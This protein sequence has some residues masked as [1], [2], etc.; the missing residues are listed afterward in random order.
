MVVVN[1]RHPHHGDHQLV[2]VPVDHFAGLNILDRPGV[3]DVHR[4]HLTGLGVLGRCR[5]QVLDLAGVEERDGVAGVAL[6]HRV[7]NLGE[8]AVGHRR[9]ASG[10]RPLVDPVEG[11]L[12][13]GGELR[14]VE[15][16]LVGNLG[17]RLGQ[18]GRRVNRGRSVDRPGAGGVVAVLGRVDKGCRTAFNLSSGRL[19][20]GLGHGS[21]LLGRWLVSRRGIRRYCRLAFRRSGCRCCSRALGVRA[22]RTCRGGT[23]RRSTDHGHS[24]PRHRAAGAGTCL[25]GRLVSGGLPVGGGVGN[26]GVGD[27]ADPHGH[28]H[29]GGHHQEP[30]PAKETNFV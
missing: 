21:L 3:P 2:T 17:R 12:L 6:D 20:L 22:R 26:V 29:H 9:L 30:L 8:V 13:V 19:G 7:G 15:A 4:F 18:A 16:G 14:Y 27:G 11:L 23:F 24:L 10:P 28:R 5:R 25:A 1:V